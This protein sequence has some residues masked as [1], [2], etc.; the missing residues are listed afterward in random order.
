MHMLQGF[1]Q[2]S[3]DCHHR[4]DECC[5]RYPSRYGNQVL[6][7]SDAQ[8]AL[9]FL[10]NKYIPVVGVFRHTPDS[11]D[12]CVFTDKLLYHIHVWS[13]WCHW[14]V[15]HF[16]SEE[17]CDLEWRSYPGTGQRNF[18]LSSLHHGVFPITPCVIERAMLSN[19]TFKLEFHR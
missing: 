5:M 14:H 18:T 13:L 10:L 16:D 3:P 4:D 19:I 15:D 12:G 2:G 11:F 9:L 6:P 1:L 17:F 7:V 8:S